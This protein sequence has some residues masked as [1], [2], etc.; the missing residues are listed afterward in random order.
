M[1]SAAYSVRAT[2]IL[3]LPLGLVA[4]AGAAFVSASDERVIVN[5]FI[6]L[7]LALSIQTFSGPSGIIT[8]G[9]VAFL[10]VGAYVTALLTIPPAL[11][12][13]EAQG[14][15]SFLAH[16]E[17]ALPL[18]LVASLLIAGVVAGLLG[19]AFARM[20][21]DALSMATVSLMLIFLVLFQGAGDITGGTQ[22]LYAIPA[23][24]TIWIAFTAAL[25]AIFIG[26]LFS[27]SRLG[28]QLAASRSDPL[29][30]ESLGVR[31]IRV[32]WVAWTLAG[33]LIGFGGGLWASYNLAF[34]P[35][36]F[37]FDLTFTLLGA[38][39]VGGLSSVT[40]GVVGVAVMTAVFEL[41]QRFERTVELTGLTQIV[42]AIFVLLILYKRPNGLLG[43]AEL[44]EAIRHGRQRLRP[45][46][47]PGPV[48]RTS[49]E[50]N[51]ALQERSGAPQSP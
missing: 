48:E 2:A 44:P 9:H 25:A 10:G 30:A 50:K 20:E 17:L 22:G 16:A 47:R 35:P 7:V 51:V 38:L 32:R 1:G 41:L 43:F 27:R 21:A 4:V 19:L 29:A 18:A 24:T 33:A 14:L 8:F 5:F 46:S 11:K 26:Q 31:L 3:A 15:P 28:V 12:L 39:V 42:L 40:G 6:T 45:A 23:S 13:T 37:G 34:A 36:A 49:E